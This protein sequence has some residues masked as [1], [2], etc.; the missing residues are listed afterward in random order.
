MLVG[1]P[2]GDVKCRTVK[3]PLLSINYSDPNLYNN[4]IQSIRGVELMFKAYH[5]L[6]QDIVYYPRVNYLSPYYKHC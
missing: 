1:L 5:Y 4:A 2:T 3:A 6:S